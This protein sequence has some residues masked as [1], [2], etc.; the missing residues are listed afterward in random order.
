MPE[1]KEKSFY[2]NLLRR[3]QDAKAGIAT[4][5]LMGTADVISP[6]IPFRNKHLCRR[7]PIM[8]L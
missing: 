7:T 3:I 6:G 5:G 2:N 4:A 1:L 8:R